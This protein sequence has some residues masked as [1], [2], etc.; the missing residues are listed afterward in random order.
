MGIIGRFLR[1]LPRCSL[2]DGR[3][4]LVISDFEL[5]TSRIAARYELSSIGIGHQ[6]AFCF[7]IPVSGANLLSRWVLH[8]FAPVDIPIGLHWHH[9]DQPILP[10]I[11]PSGLS[12]GSPFDENK[13]LV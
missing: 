7:D 10:P 5:L 6:Y 12:T 1:N 9:F 3:F 13:I 4:D 11:V 8:S 2:S